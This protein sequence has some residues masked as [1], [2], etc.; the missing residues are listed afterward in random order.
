MSRAEHVAGTIETGHRGLVLRADDGGVWELENTSAMRQL[1]GAHVEVMGQ[2]AGFN[3]LVCDHIRIAGQTR[4]PA[5]RL[6]LEF[7]ATAALVAYGL[8]TAI[9]TVI[10]THD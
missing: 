10:S 9:A 6:R 3:G 2:R 4:S 7:V 8:Y 5:S 1:V